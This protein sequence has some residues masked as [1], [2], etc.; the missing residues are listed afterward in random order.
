MTTEI[1]ESSVPLRHN[2]RNSMRRLFSVASVIVLLS[3][4]DKENR[5]LSPTSPVHP[6][7]RLP[8]LRSSP[9]HCLALSS[10]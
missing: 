2:F 1:R 6:V 10:K 7:Q 4:C 3:A 9:T 8:P 5:V